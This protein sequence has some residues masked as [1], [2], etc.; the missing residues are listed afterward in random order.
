MKGVDVAKAA[1]DTTEEPFTTPREREA[2]AYQWET[3]SEDEGEEIDL[4]K[5]SPFVGQYKG[6]KVV[7]I[8]ND[9]TKEMEDTNLY[10]FTD[11]KGARRSLWGNFRVDQAFTDSKAP[12]PGDMVKIEWHGKTDLK[13]GRTFNRISVFKAA[14]R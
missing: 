10:L 1:D 14:A 5:E 8:L 7:P 4:S 12:S 2:E 9:D 11:T 3:V 6:V 13:G